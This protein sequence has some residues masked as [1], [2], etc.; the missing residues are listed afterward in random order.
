[1]TVATESGKCIFR[2]LYSR[3]LSNYCYNK[4]EV[5]KLTFSVCR[6]KFSRIASTNFQKRLSPSS[7]VRSYLNASLISIISL[8][9]KLSVETTKKVK[10]IKSIIKMKNNKENAESNCCF[11]IG[12]LCRC[13][14]WR[15]PDWLGISQIPSLNSFKNWSIR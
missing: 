15:W 2:L 11:H 7:H 14:F 9:T 3:I 5:I 12:E 8:R 10:V 4:S 6:R 13:K 1:M